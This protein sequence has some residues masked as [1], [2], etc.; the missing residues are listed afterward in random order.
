[1]VQKRALITGING[2][3]GPY[4][5]DILQ[6][7]GYHVTGVSRAEADLTDAFALESAIFKNEPDE[8]YNLAGQSSVSMSFKD[9]AG[10]E[11]TTGIGAQRLLEATRKYRDVSKKNV[12]FFQASS[13][14][15]FGNSPPPQDEQTPFDPQSPYGKAKLYAYNQA[16]K[17]RKEY[18]LFVC[19]GILFNHE[20]PRRP[21]TFVTRKITMAVARIKVGLQDKLSVGNISITRDWGYAPEYMEA[22]FLMMQHDKPDDYVIGTGIAHTI[23]D[24]IK[25]AFETVDIIDFEKYIY[26][27]PALYRPSEVNQTLSNPRK[28][29]EVLGW[30]AQKNFNELVSL[31]VLSDLKN[32]H[33]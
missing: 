30:K 21:E 27:D 25:V 17:Y 28:A 20:S 2:Q 33:K 32:I 13:S 29:F 6:K 10:T 15:M 31:M 1:M 16:V 14:E 3:D 12:K 18:G 9:P 24:F 5:A 26:V 11:N 7:K 23:R 22:A 19:S 4:L 8:I